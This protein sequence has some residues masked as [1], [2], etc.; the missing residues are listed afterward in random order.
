MGNQT[1]W[2]NE[3]SSGSTRIRS[4]SN[5]GERP[6]GPLKWDYKVTGQEMIEVL[7]RLVLEPCDR[8]SRTV[9]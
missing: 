9:H 8:E 6:E 5:A 3:Y 2:W 4:S 7:K 1:I